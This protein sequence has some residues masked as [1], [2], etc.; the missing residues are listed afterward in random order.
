M[1]P[2]NFSAWMAQQRVLEASDI[3][4]ADDLIAIGKKVARRRDGEQYQEFAMTLEELFKLGLN[5]YTTV[6]EEGVSLPARG[7]MNFVGAGVTVT[8]AGGK[9]V[10]TIPTPTISLVEDITYAALVAKVGASTLEPGKG[11]NITDFATKHVI[12]N[13]G[14]TVN[15]GAVEALLVKAISA[16]KLDMLAESTTYPQDIIHYELVDSSTAGGDKGRIFYREDTKQ[17]ISTAYDWRNVKFRRFRN[18]QTL[19]L[20][21]G[22]S[23]L[24]APG[25]KI[26]GG[27]SGA[28]AY[29]IGGTGAN[30]LRVVNHTG[31]FIGGEV[32]T[33]SNGSTRTTNTVADYSVDADTHVDNGRAFTDVFTFGDAVATDIYNVIISPVN[34]TGISAPT[35]LL[36]NITFLT[37]SH[38]V[39]LSGNS[40]NCSMSTCVNF[41]ALSYFYDNYFRGGCSDFFFS[42]DAYSNKLYGN[43]FRNA[44]SA[45][46]LSNV[47]AGTFNNNTINGY[48]FGL[49]DIATGFQYNTINVRVT[50]S[51]IETPSMAYN[52]I[53]ADVSAQTF[54]YAATEITQSY[55]KRIIKGSDSTL[56]LEYYNGAALVYVDPLTA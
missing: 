16:N 25:Y 10:V 6:Q 3:V 38:D 23:S 1:E 13:S 54:L 45:N 11:Y 53:D 14:G 2:L 32:I 29:V 8:D 19:N 39:Y 18:A 48:Y 44:V 15:T 41:K 28:I 36:N 30:I 47:I 33:L 35:D 43:C 12:P 52:I 5:G 21:A 40:Y 24:N 51:I 46:F 42:S 4:P 49:N 55:S 31:L 34:A 9:T 26:T 27:T 22:G 17:N 50:S 56:Y 37:G 20:V 7:I